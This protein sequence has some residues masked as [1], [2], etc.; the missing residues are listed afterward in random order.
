MARPNCS[1]PASARAVNLLIWQS[2][3][4]AA[5]LVAGRCADQHAVMAQQWAEPVMKRSVVFSASRG[6]MGDGTAPWSMRPKKQDRIP[7][8]CGR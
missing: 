3:L 4:A 7:G 1:S 2:V 8:W 6:R 5:Y